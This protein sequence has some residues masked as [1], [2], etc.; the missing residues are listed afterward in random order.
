MVG[1]RDDVTNV[2]LH[3]LYVWFTYGKCSYGIVQHQTKLR[4]RRKAGWVKM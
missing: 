2:L 1:V 3:L 4:Q